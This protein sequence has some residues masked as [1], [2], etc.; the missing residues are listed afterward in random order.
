MT[1]HR[2][3]VSP[4]S[5]LFPLALV[6]IA[7][8]VAIVGLVT[9]PERTWPNL[10]VNGFYVMS[11]GV[12]A[13]VFLAATRLSGARWSASLR[14]IPEALMLTLPV[15]AVL[16]LVLYFGRTT[17]FPWTHPGIFDHD[18]AIAGRATYLNQSFVFARWVIVL[19]LWAAFAWLFRRTSLQQDGNVRLSL[20]HHRRL[21]RY[22]AIFVLVFAFSFTAGAYDWIISLDPH[23]FSTMFAVYIF[24][25]AWVQGIAAVTLGAIVLRERN[26]VG[27]AVTEDQLHD[28]GKMLFAFTVFWMY[29]WTCQYLLI[30]YGNIPEEVTHYLQ[31]TNGPWLFLFVL[32]PILNWVVPFLGLMKMRSKRAPGVMTAVCVIL[33]FGHWLDLYL[34]IMPALA[35]APSI[36]PSE[37]VIAAGYIA[38]VYIG[39]TRNL[40]RAPLVP[41]NDP[42]MAAESLQH[43]HAAHS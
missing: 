26:M 35:P 1:T 2:F 6:L 15:S 16:M 7:A 42:I 31:R 20:H 11:V 17:L 5:Q 19:V 24:A 39:F 22:A 9:S 30:W 37:I 25:G 33:L 12:S 23:W 18:P 43:G 38:L 21:N 8:V 32:N 27:G 34:Q 3:T 40:A 41:I 4:R 10:L 28:L 29:I 14:R 13:I 36:G